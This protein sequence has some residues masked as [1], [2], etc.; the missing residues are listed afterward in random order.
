MTCLQLHLQRHVSQRR[1]VSALG[2]LIGSEN[3][4]LD[5]PL[6]GCRDQGLSIVRDSDGPRRKLCDTRD[7]DSPELNA[8][9]QIDHRH[10]VAAAVAN[11]QQRAVSAQDPARLGSTPP[12]S[13]LRSSETGVSRFRVD[14]V[15]C[16]SST[17]TYIPVS[18]TTPPIVIPGS[19]TNVCAGPAAPQ[20]LT[21]V[22]ALRA[23]SRLAT[24]AS[25]IDCAVAISRIAR[26][27]RADSWPLSV[28]G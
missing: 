13:A 26:N 17:R 14:S 24:A 7:R 28:P 23:P 20:L 10:V 27:P 2:H 4:F 25:G 16:S 15:P 12:E 3:E 6:I 11:V 8:L 21:T 9:S 22:P 1:E 19:E 18:T 5:R